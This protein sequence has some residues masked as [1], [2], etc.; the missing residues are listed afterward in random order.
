MKPD[1]G[2]YYEMLDAIAATPP[3][4]SF[5]SGKWPDLETW[6]SKARAK[7]LEL[8]AFEPPNVQL[9]PSI[10]ARHYEEG[11]VVEEISYEMPYGP[12]AHGLFL[13]PKE[14]GSELPAVVALHDHGEFFYY[15][16]EKLVSFPNEPVVL[17]EYRDK[18]YGG[19]SWAT[20]LAKRGFAVLAVDSFLWGSRKIPIGSMNE[21]LQKKFEGVGPESEE[22]IRKYNEFWASNE[23]VLVVDSILN[24]GTS[25]PAIFAYEDR[26]SIDYLL[27]RSEIDANRIG[28]GGL[29]MGGLRTIFLAGLDKRV[30]CAF[31]V[32]FMTTMRG[33]LRNKIRCPPGHGLLMYVPELFKLLDLPDVISIRTP[34]P[35]MVQY[36]EE[37]E[38]FTRRRPARRE[39]KDH[40]HLFQERLPEQLCRQILPRPTQIQCSNAGRRFQVARKSPFSLNIIQDHALV[41]PSKSN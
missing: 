20:A 38:L 24:S 33:V 1:M 21:E 34:A 13:Y 5:L 7:V 35:L 39:P 27:T 10:E 11:V 29:S 31:C 30:R 32:G 36:N 12:R 23:C 22:Y 40:G 15:G 4:L 16:K 17:R 6:K 26:R 25:W 19:R 37:D 18:Y 8:L 2:I 14:A 28:C 41:Y 3:S 9:N